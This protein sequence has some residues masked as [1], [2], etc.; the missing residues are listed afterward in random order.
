[1]HTYQASYLEVEY[2]IIPKYYW[3]ILN[4]LLLGDGT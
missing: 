1:M 4:R 2:Y 3:N